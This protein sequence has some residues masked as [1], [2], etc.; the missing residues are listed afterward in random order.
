[1]ITL[2]RDSAGR[3]SGGPT[4]QGIEAVANLERRGLAEPAKARDAPNAAR[5]QF[6]KNRQEYPD[7]LPDITLEYIVKSFD[8]AARALA[9]STEFATLQDRGCAVEELFKTKLR[10]VSEIVSTWPSGHDVL[11]FLKRVREAL[12]ERKKRI[13]KMPVGGSNP[14]VSDGS[15]THSVN[16]APAPAPML[17][18]TVAGPPGLTDTREAAPSNEADGDQR[19]AADEPAASADTLD[20]GNLQILRGADGELKRAVTLDIARRFG[21]VTKRA[22]HHATH[23]GKLLTEGKGQ[24]RRVL[25]DSLLKYFPPEK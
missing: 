14:A 11:S 5:E 2:E 6:E 4:Q 25:V 13:A 20:K 7:D 18:E 3:V 15:T 23:H 19:H 24:Q 9:L 21:G 22:I 8:T 1:M 10:E 12:L 16:A 17:D